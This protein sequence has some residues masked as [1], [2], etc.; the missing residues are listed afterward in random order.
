MNRQLISILFCTVLLAITF[1]FSTSGLWGV[2]PNESQHD[3][4]AT[5]L[6]ENM[7]KHL[8]SELQTFE[9]V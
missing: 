1:T 4:T 9:K 3:E 7:G 5:S 8:K 2:A 6:F